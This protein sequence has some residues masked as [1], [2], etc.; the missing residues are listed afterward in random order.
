MN[1]I[2]VVLVDELDEERVEKTEILA[3]CESV[4][5]NEFNI[6]AQSGYKSEYMLLVWHFEY[7]NQPYAEIDGVRYSIYRTHRKPDSD[8]IELYLGTKV[9]V[10][11]G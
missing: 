1:F 2:N 6:A 4:T 9:G 5:R 10:Y 11:V 7:S 8:K 3:E